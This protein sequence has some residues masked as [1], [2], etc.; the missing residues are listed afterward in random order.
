ME[1]YLLTLHAFITLLFNTTYSKEVDKQD[2]Y[3]LFKSHE[4]LKRLDVLP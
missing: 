4:A 3:L 2:F 1:A